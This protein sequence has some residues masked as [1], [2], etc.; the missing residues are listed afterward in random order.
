MIFSSRTIPG[1]ENAVNRI[2]NALVRRGIEVITDRTD[3]VHVSGHPRRGEME[4]MYA[5]TRPQIAVPVHGEDLHLATHAD[6]ARQQGVPTVVRARNGTVV[7]LWPGPAAIVEHVTVGRLYRDGE[8]VVPANDHGIPDRRKLAF[9]GIVSVA[10]AIDERGEIAG[11][12]R[13][14][15]MGIPEK[16]R[17]GELFEEIVD[18]AVTEALENMPRARRRDPEAIEQTV[19]RAV[20]GSLRN[21]WGKKPACHVLVIEV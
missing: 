8:V 5:W 2:I 7:R 1:N 9:A 20:R 18:A 19:V 10:V 12:V 17:T 16:T 13:I 4:R 11:N 21:Q 15:Q 3:L 14:E 6:F